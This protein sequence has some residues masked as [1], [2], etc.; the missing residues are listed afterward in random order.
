MKKF[1]KLE[2]VLL[3]LTLIVLICGISTV[4]YA[5]SDVN[6][7]MNIREVTGAQGSNVPANTPAANNS[8]VA[9]IRVQNQNTNTALPKLGANDTAMWVLIIACAGA[10][11][12]TYK[13]VRDY[14]I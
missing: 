14:D 2:K 6:E 5:T 8:N 10:A 11:I 7:I 13:K 9:N 4:N 12:Y 3:M 1:G